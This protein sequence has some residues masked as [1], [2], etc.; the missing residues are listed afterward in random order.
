MYRIIIA[1]P[2]TTTQVRPLAA[3]TDLGALREGRKH[4]SYHGSQM[5][6]Q[7]WIDAADTWIDIG[8]MTVTPG[9]CKWQRP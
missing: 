7:Q 8:Y 4:A 2:N 1:E 3:K 5:T 6:V 9:A